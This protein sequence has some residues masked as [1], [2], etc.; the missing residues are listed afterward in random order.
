MSDTRLASVKV[1]PNARTR[2]QK[3]A[4]QILRNGGCNR[5]YT[6]NLK[7]HFNFLVRPYK[8]CGHEYVADTLTDFNG[9][10][11]DTFGLLESWLPAVTYS[12][13]IESLVDYG[14]VDNA[15]QA[16]AEYNRRRAERP[17]QFVGQHIIVLQPI[18]KNYGFR[19]HKNGGYY[20]AAPV[21]HEYF[22]DET[23][24]GLEMV[25]V[26]NI[27][28]IQNEKEDDY[29]NVESW[30]LG[31][32]REQSI[33][34][35]RNLGLTGL[36]EKAKKCNYVYTGDATCELRKED[37]EWHVFQLERADDRVIAKNVDQ[38]WFDAG[39]TDADKVYPW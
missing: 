38:E 26:Y 29:G 8:P 11:V 39:L 35:L 6:R 28:Q 33:R 21:C 31:G 25:Y 30:N 9:V 20:G 17:E 23:V 32:Y 5:Q 18:G 14:V 37:G 12:K 3:F 34:K 13:V 1:K 27:I 19:W 10:Y 16:V 36:A 24:E 4:R 2:W 15:T 22:D 7:K